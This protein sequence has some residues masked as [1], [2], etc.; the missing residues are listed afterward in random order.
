MELRVTTSTIGPVSVVALDGT[1]DLA[2][3]PALRTALHH[4]A[5]GTAPVVA[6]DI[7]AVSV[8]DDVALGLLVGLAARLRDAGRELVLVCTAPRLLDRLASTRLDRILDIR[9][10]V[11]EA[12]TD[13]SSA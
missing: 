2:A 7:D 4:A 9:S 8:L 3:A 11:A 12:C 13:R 6:V 1:A 5:G 10:S